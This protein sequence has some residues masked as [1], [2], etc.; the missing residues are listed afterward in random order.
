M[1]HYDIF[2]AAL[3]F[4]ALYQGGAELSF[5]MPNVTRDT[6]VFIQGLVILTVGAIATGIGYLL[7]KGV[8]LIFN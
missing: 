7:G 5:D 4:G 6:M 3:L 2:F 1:R 8:E